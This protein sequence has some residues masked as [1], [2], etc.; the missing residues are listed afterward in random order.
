MKWIA[1]RWFVLWLVSFAFVAVVLRGYL[2]VPLVPLLGA[3]VLTLGLAIAK[4]V[5]AK[6]RDRA[7]RRAFGE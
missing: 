5:A 2:G 3:G 7:S 1:Q 4:R 6:K